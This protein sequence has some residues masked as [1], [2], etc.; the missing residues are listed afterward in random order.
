MTVGQFGNDH[1]NSYS[2]LLGEYKKKKKITIK[3]LIT[4]ILIIDTSDRVNHLKFA[5]VIV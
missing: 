5:T 2:H 3:N 1:P 4:K